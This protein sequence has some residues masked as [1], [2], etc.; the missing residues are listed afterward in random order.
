MDGRS[1]SCCR[2]RKPYIT[3]GCATRRGGGACFHLLVSCSHCLGPCRI[4][5]FP[6]L[7]CCEICSKVGCPVCHCSG[8]DSPAHSEPCTTGDGESKDSPDCYIYSPLSI[9]CC[10]VLYPPL[11]SA[12][13]CC[14]RGTDMIKLGPCCHFRDTAI[15]PGGRWGRANNLDARCVGWVEPRDD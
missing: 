13:A 12:Q 6:A 9:V 15:M 8:G 2:M 3:V 11:A 4:P 1:C 7:F 10:V 5:C 14:M